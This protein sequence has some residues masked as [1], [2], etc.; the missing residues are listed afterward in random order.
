MGGSDTSSE[1]M[2]NLGCTPEPSEM[3]MEAV[4][5][6]FLK[7]NVN[8]PCGQPTVYWHPRT[9][10]KDKLCTVIL[11]FPRDL[12][13]DHS[14]GSLE[15]ETNAI[16]WIRCQGL[17]NREHS[18]GKRRGRALTAGEASQDKKRDW[19]RFSSKRG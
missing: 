4:M 11:S 19:P 10:T 14:L 16:Q 18:L 7:T 13:P 2:L 6:L 9:T 17:W 15:G 12:C 1:V 8:C 3:P 5:K